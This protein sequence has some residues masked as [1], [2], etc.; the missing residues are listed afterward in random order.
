[1]QQNSFGKKE[2]QVE[3]LK[4]QCPKKG[5]WALPK[6][7]SVHMGSVAERDSVWAGGR[8]HAA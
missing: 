7:G 8:E 6:H 1:M 3:K 2:L 5:Q 4:K